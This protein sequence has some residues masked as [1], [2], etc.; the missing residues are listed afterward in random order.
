MNIASIANEAVCFMFQSLSL[1]LWA[2]LARLA[3][4]IE[5]MGPAE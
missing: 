1:V 2:G 5:T 3:A 4:H